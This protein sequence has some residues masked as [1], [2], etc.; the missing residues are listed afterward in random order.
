MSKK[1]LYNHISK[2]LQSHF[3]KIYNHISKNVNFCVSDMYEN[4]GSLGNVC[5][6]CK[7]QNHLPINKESKICYKK[8]STI[9]IFKIEFSKNT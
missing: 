3:K 6:L 2:T 4:A 8:A 7:F 5:L 1:P 9:S